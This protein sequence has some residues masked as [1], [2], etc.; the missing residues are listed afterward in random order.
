MDP[1][2]QQSML[3]VLVRAF[4]GFTKPF[5]DPDRR[6]VRRVDQADDVIAVHFLERE[7]EAAP[8]RLGRVAFSPP[9]APQRPRQLESGPAVRLMKPDPPHQ[10]ARLLFEHA[11]H[12]EA[13]EMPVTD[14][15]GQMPPRL[16][17]VELRTQR[18]V[19]DLRIGVDLPVLFEV[20]GVQHPQKQPI[21]GER[22]SVEWCYFHAVRFYDAV[23]A[24]LSLLPWPA[25]FVEVRAAGAAQSG[26]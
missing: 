22:R 24:T 17:T 21:G 9:C 6:G 8:R 25:E 23:F 2:H 7:R 26:Q 16:G 1:V 11:P 10:P 13:P 12:S 19:R 3:S 4:D 15:P 18:V 20:R 14:E 5:G